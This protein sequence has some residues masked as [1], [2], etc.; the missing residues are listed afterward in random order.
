MTGN[1]LS[2]CFLE[3]RKKRVFLGYCGGQG[4][5]RARQQ[6]TVRAGSESFFSPFNHYFLSF[7]LYCLVHH[8]MGHH[9]VT[10]THHSQK[11]LVKLRH[12]LTCLFLP[13][14]DSILSPSVVL[15]VFPRQAST[16]EPASAPEKATDSDENK[17]NSEEKTG[18]ERNRTES[19][20]TKTEPSANPKEPAFKQSEAQSTHTSPKSEWFMICVLQ[21][22]FICMAVLCLFILFSS[23]L[24]G[25]MQRNRKVLRKRR[26]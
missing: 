14:T 24:S 25:A 6:E 8:L 16:V 21:I 9:T 10:I 26:H 19:P 11:T 4:N 23:I 3:C 13:F 2:C 1:E 17:G 5:H 15:S 20:S 18:D 7:L 12:L 22:L